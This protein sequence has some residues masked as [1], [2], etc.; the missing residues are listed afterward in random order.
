MVDAVKVVADGI[1]LEKKIAK[2]A[3]HNYGSKRRSATHD[4]TNIG[5]DDSA[6]VI[7]AATGGSDKS[8]EVNDTT[9]ETNTS[10]ADRTENN[11][12]PA[13]NAGTNDKKESDN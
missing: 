13:D 9:N 5:K 10:S 12:T 7:N 11:E 8:A 1:R 4:A 3:E 6:I 2:S